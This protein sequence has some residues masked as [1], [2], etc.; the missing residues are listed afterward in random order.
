MP[1]HRLCAAALLSL[2]LVGAPFAA[3]AVGDDPV[4]LSMGHEQ[5]TASQFKRVVADTPPQVKEA[6]LADPAAFARRYADMHLLAQLAESRQLEQDPDVRQQ[7]AWV[8]EGVL[9]NAAKDDLYRRAQVSDEEAKRYYE[10]HKGDF[11]D[12]TLQHVVLRYQGSGIAPRAGQK[13]MSVSEAK[14]E[15]DQLRAQVLHGTDFA[16]IV[17]RYSD[18]DDSKA[19]GGLLPETASRNLLP[20]IAQGI[21]GLKENDVSQ[22]IKT[23]YG[24]HLVKVIKRVDNSFEDAKPHVVILLKSEQMDRQIEAMKQAKRAKLDAGFFQ[25]SPAP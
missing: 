3:H 22:P 8:R 2:P 11:V 18:D 19:D 10:A 13:D 15:A 20:E 17:Q 6:A 14:A 25:A 4:V 23:R 16:D 5:W 1:L 24:Y 9:A 12:Y 21:A 7:L